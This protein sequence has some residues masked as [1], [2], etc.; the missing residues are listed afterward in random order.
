MRAAP[1]LR[2]TPARSAP[3]APARTMLPRPYRARRPSGD[4]VRAFRQSG[5]DHAVAGD[6]LRKALFAP[7]LRTGGAHRQ[8]EISNFRRRIPDANIR[9]LR[10][11]KTKIA[12]HAARIL[13]RLGTI[14]R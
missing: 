2:E 1:I 5:P 12:E 7:A 14:G 13:H 10:Q 4:L 8:H 3:V 9:P 6:E 11:L